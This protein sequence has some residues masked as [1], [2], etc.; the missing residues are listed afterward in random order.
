MRLL[1][2]RVAIRSLER[3]FDTV[4]ADICRYPLFHCHSM[5]YCSDNRAATFLQ[6]SENPLVTSKRSSQMTDV[7]I[8]Q[9]QSNASVFIIAIIIIIIIIITPTQSLLSIS[10]GL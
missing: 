2:I 8:D 7:S 5:P 6:S 1:Y 10:Q 3:S 4:S 9:C